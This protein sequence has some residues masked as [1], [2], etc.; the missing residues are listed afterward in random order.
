MQL[1]R[2]IVAVLDLLREY[3][4][5][6]LHWAV[7]SHRMRF[8]QG[9]RTHLNRRGKRRYSRSVPVRYG[10]SGFE[11]T[12]RTKPD[13]KEIGAALRRL[14]MDAGI[15]LA[16]M[17]ER[18]GMAHQNLSRLEHGKKEPMLSSVNK[19]LRTGGL[20]LVLVAK[21]KPSLK[22]TAATTVTPT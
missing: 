4:R 17:A 13:A 11:L 9:T 8:G 21:P 2:L 6:P 7:C 14:R 5:N 19:Y 3:V 12:V 10:N 22:R 20:Y 16:D 15:S 1:L 18:M